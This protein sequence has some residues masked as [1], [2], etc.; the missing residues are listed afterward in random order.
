M[1][2]VA[3]RTVPAGTCL[4]PSN[5]AAAGHLLATPVDLAKHPQSVLLGGIGGGLSRS[6]YSLE[7]QEVEKDSYYLGQTLSFKIQLSPPLTTGS[8]SC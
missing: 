8:R 3:A 2:G 1:A 6:Y 7:A 4:R 5:C